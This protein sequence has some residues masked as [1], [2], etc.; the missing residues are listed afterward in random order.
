MPPRHPV[1]E[2]EESGSD[3]E[4]P[5]VGTAT[6]KQTFEDGHGFPI[7]FFIHESVKKL[8]QRDKLTSDIQACLD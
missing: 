4:D 2:E 7:G 6:A 1:E 5:H 8:D 3:E